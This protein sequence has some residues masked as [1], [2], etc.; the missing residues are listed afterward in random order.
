[1]TDPNSPAFSPP[2][3]AQSSILKCGLTKREYFAALA[4]QGLLAADKNLAKDAASLM[5][6]SVVAVQAT[7][8]LITALNVGATS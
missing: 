2:G 6:A 4:L 5:H 7:D 1:M 3:V 8:C